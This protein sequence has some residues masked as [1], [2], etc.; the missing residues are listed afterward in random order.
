MV[1]TYFC[2]DKNVFNKEKYKIDSKSNLG[3][4]N[5]IYKKKKLS[6]KILVSR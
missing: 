4:R 2:I 3:I 5:K 1:K 6:L